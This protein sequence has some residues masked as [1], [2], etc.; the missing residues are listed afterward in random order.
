MANSSAWPGSYARNFSAIPW[1]PARD[2][3]VLGYWLAD[4]PS[5]A[6]IA[7]YAEAAQN[8]G[9][10]QPGALRWVNLL[11]SYASAVQT[12][13]ANYRCQHGTVLTE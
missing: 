12:G 7:P 3:M 8:I 13:F 9:A 5:K 4:E 6:L 2:P 1:P 11:P 10:L